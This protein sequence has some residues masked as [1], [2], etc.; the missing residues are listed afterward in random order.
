MA[1]ISILKMYYVEKI[2]SDIMIFSALEKKLLS[3]LVQKKKW[4]CI[5]IFLYWY[6]WYHICDLVIILKLFSFF[7]DR[8][9]VFILLSI[10]AFF[11]ISPS[12]KYIWSYKERSG[13]TPVLPLKFYYTKT[14]KT[15]AAFISKWLEF[16]FVS[17]LVLLSV[18][19]SAPSFSVVLEP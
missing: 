13:R 3:P 11:Q 17:T 19:D 15:M 5:R 16:D 9:H 12:R 2:K 6:K 18:E 4:L 14:L 1:S 10:S 8:P 7:F